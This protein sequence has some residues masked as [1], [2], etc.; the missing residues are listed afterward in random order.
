MNAP[1]SDSGDPTT[2]R[3]EYDARLV[4]ETVVRHLS[5]R[6]E[7]YVY[8]K[9]RNA[10]Y[11]IMEGEIRERRFQGLHAE[12]FTRLSL[13][14][15][16][17]DALEEQPALL[18]GAAHCCVLAASSAA[19]EGADL[20]DVLG[21]RRAASS[22]KVVVIRLRPAMLLD[23]EALRPFLRH[24]F[25]HLV[26]ILSRDFGYRPVLPRSEAG[27]SHDRLVRDRYRVAWDTW[28]DGRLSSRGWA[29][30]QARER[31]LREF[32]AAFGLASDAAEKAFTAF[33][34]ATHLT[35][36]QILDFAVSPSCDSLTSAGRG[37]AGFCALCRFPSFHRV[38]GNDVSSEM[39]AAI[40]DDFP[41]WVREQGM[42]LQCADLYRVCAISKAAEAAC[43]V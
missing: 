35:H 13:G 19:D 42:C 37:E 3:I 7:E 15:P 18:Q 43:D 16:V 32:A 1:L 22:G 26:D 20:H 9:A 38:A 23:R 4:E 12:W 14:G 34:N 11:E 39:E 31:R 41:E 2:F 28:I 21:D 17:Q 30:S 24:E 10:L 29:P 25:Q 36:Q 6:P 27:P 40:R 5:G 8:R 33:F